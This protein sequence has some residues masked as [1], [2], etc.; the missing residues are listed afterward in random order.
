MLDLL[1]IDDESGS[2]SGDSDRNSDLFESDLDGDDE[3]G[4][5]ATLIDVVEQ[6]KYLTRSER[7]E[8]SSEFLYKYFLDLPDESFRQLTQM[9]KRLYMCLLDMIFKHHVF[10]NNSPYPQ[11]PMFV[12]LA[13][14]L[15]RFGHELVSTTSLY[16]IRVERLDFI[17]P[18]LRKHD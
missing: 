8:K 11:A 5:L 3:I 2:S 9:N 4:D 18:T 6:R 1:N 10:H 13:V 7:W 15:D 12:Q 14:A 17:I 16:W